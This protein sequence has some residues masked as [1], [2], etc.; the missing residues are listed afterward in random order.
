VTPPN[1]PR[2]WTNISSILEQP[3]ENVSNLPLDSSLYG[4]QGSTLIFGGT[5][6]ESLWIRVTTN[7]ITAANLT[8]TRPSSGDLFTDPTDLG[9]KSEATLIFS[10]DQPLTIEPAEPDPPGLS[11]WLT[12]K[13]PS[14]GIYEF[15]GSAPK[16]SAGLQG[17]DPFVN[18]FTGA[19][20]E[21]LTAVPSVPFD[22][23]NIEQYGASNSVWHRWT[24]AASGQYELGIGSDRGLQFTLYR[25]DSLDN[26][27]V[28]TSK[29]FSFN[30]PPLVSLFRFLATIDE[31]HF[32]RVTGPNAAEGE[33]Q[34]ELQPATPPSNDHFANAPELT[35]DLPIIDSGT[36]RFSSLESPQ[37]GAINLVGQERESS[38]WWKWIPTES[39]SFE[40]QAEAYLGLFEDGDQVGHDLTASYGRLR[41]AALAG[42]EYHFRIAHRRESEATVALTLSPV[43]GLEHATAATAIA[44]GSATSQISE[45]IQVL[46]GTALIA[47]QKTTGRAVFRWT[48]QSS[49][50]VKI[51]SITGSQFVLSAH[52]DETLRNSLLRSSNQASQTHDFID[53]TSHFN[54]PFGDLSAPLRTTI[55]IRPQIVPRRSQGFMPIKAGITYFLVGTPSTPFETSAE[56]TTTVQFQISR[57][58]APP[59]F[60][61]AQWKR[62]TDRNIIEATLSIKAPNGLASGTINLDSRRKYFDASH[63]ISG[64]AFNGQYRLTIPIPFSSHDFQ[65]TPRLTL[66]DHAG[67]SQAIV[68]DEITLTSELPDT[69]LPDRQ[70][71]QLLGIAG[72]ATEIFLTGT[73]TLLSLEMAITDHGGSGFT[74]GEIILPDAFIQSPLGQI[75]DHDR[76]VIP[77]NAAQRIAG[78]SQAGLYRVEVTIP[79]NTVSGILNCRI[80]DRAGNISGVWQ[81][82]PGGDVTRYN[83]KKGTSLPVRLIASQQFDD[84][85]LIEGTLQAGQFAV[86][87]PIPSQRAG[88]PHWLT[89]EII[90]QDGAAAIASGIAPLEISDQPFGDQRNPILTRFEIFS[91]QI[92]ITQREET[93][94]VNLAAHDDRSGLEAT[95]TIFDYD[96][97]S[98]ASKL[99]TCLDPVLNCTAEITLP[100]A[101]LASSSSQAR[102][103]LTLKDATGR[104]TVYGGID[105]PSWPDDTEPS[106]TLAPSAPSFLNHW[107]QEWTDL[108]EFPSV[109]NHDL[110]RDGWSDLIEFALGTDPATPAPQD[111]FAYQLPSLTL[112]GRFFSG[113]QELRIQSFTSQIAPWFKFDPDEK[114]TDGRFQLSIEG[115][116][117]LENWETVSSPFPITPSTPASI[118]I[119]DSTPVSQRTRWYRLNIRPHGESPEDN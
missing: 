11:R 51:S 63:R 42:R 17:I 79:A 27:A 94:T 112:D 39:G 103:Q 85:A 76:G 19:Q 70:A 38:V 7:Q 87:L 43:S 46:G 68:L 26:L 9:E 116:N 80:R 93:I 99:I 118:W 65:T 29:R 49:G 86:A 83:F 2:R 84:Q 101:P 3:P 88:G 60:L 47:G 111:L 57:I 20:L 16:S 28:V 109:Q 5:S 66:S 10:L 37:D 56:S 59:T 108:E 62:F 53:W 110:D 1:S 13:A 22:S 74:S 50:W 61:S 117:N 98:L 18:I 23:G 36:T 54:R 44:L 95:L 21:S 72:G 90:A 92:D 119:S 69:Y 32:L 8:I 105:S 4:S 113:N 6:G 91:D 30:P 45:S 73:E 34:L 33:Y 31:V 52:P 107:Y 71:P 82:R 115:S 15:S 14:S 96:G 25:G 40:L 67:I 24:P 35:G 78:D 64:D 58:A 104:T 102:I 41:F 12:W 77:F 100:L 89:W 81:G 75:S 55:K 106:L 97:N 114:L 48:P